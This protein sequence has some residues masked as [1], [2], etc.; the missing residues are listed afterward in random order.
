MSFHL[1]SW[2]LKHSEAT[3]GGRL[4][5]I[6]LAEFGHDDGTRCFP[7][8]ETIAERTRMSRRGVQ[9]ALRRLE[10]EGHIETTGT[11]KYGTTVYRI[12][13]GG[14]ETAPAQMTAQNTSSTAPDPTTDPPSLKK[15]Q[16]KKK[17]LEPD[18][19]PDGFDLWLHRHVAVAHAYRVP[20]SVPRERTS[21]R[22]ALA[23]TFAALIEEGYSVEELELASE[24]VLADDF[25][26]SNGHVKPE[27][28]L[29]KTK[30]AG[31][32]DAGRAARARRLAGGKYDELDD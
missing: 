1:V 8:V 12:R 15:K 11:T 21:T 20:Q 26:R 32:I 7:S 14:E 18:E 13:M 28:V 31:R 23:Q 16:A 22:T 5:M 25:M 6:V 30:V 3:L 4:V 19:E 2:V 27:N 24:G 10:E 29:R 9:E 17:L